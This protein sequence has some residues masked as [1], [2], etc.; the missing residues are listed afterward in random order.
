MIIADKS[1]VA[2]D[3]KLTLG[4]GEEID[5]SQEGQPLE[6]IT[7]TGHI[8]PGLEKA[9][10]GMATG[11]ST[12]IT[13]QPDE[14]YGPVNE[15]LFQEIPKDQFPDTEDIQ[16]GM[17]FQA[18]GPQGPIMVSVTAVTDDI[19][20][21]D[22]NHPLAG[23]ELTFDIHIANVR[24]ASAEEIAQPSSGC[25]CGCGGSEDQKKDK[26]ECGSDCN[27]G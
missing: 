4:T 3:Y 2:I 14:G 5:K 21:V 23:K 25:G 17:T 9:I 24:E 16:P 8:I 22:M 26:S 10:I 19:V 27:C 12:T 6:F 11:E 18:Q 15:E 13:V 1:F 20:S 7:G